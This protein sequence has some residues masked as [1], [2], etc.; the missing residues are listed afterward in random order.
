MNILRV[1]KR[2]F[3]RYEKSPE[4]VYYIDVTI[5]NVKTIYNDFDKKSPYAKKELDEDIVEYIIDSAQDLG[6]QPFAIRFYFD[7][8]ISAELQSRVSKSIENYFR[9]RIALEERK[10]NEQVHSS[11][12]HFS[13]GVSLLL[14]ALWGVKML[15]SSTSVFKDI[16]RE[17][18]VIAS[19]VSLWNAMD[20]F[21]VNW[22]PFRKRTRLFT[23]IAS[24]KVLFAVSGSVTNV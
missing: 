2:I 24:S 9:Y 7:E 6:R 22:R 20:T 1:K 8:M 15:G 21:I 11:W 16:L 18:L 19:W 5:P 10:F 17:G 12:I 4:G 3:E 23:K 14:L 13:L